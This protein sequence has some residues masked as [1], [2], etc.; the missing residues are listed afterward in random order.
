VI[1]IAVFSNFI[2]V[3]IL[4]L[5]TYYLGEAAAQ[6]FLHDFAGLTMFAVALLSVF[7]IDSIFSRLLHLRM[8]R[9][10]R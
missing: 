2:R 7:V 5:I 6:G 8:E 4:I 10:P 9:L 1:P 3:I